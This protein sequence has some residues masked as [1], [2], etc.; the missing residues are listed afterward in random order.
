LS[1]AADLLQ[2]IICSIKIRQAPTRHDSIDFKPILTRIFRILPSS[3]VTAHRGYDSENNHVLDRKELHVLCVISA[4][5]E[6][7]PIWKTHARYRKQM[8]LG[9]C[10]M[11]CNEKNKK[12]ESIISVIKRL[13]G[14]RYFGVR[15]VKTSENIK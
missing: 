11:H 15:Y 8:K 7:G 14:T 4:R 6:R 1:I 12:H 2:Q 13:F 5:Y 9:Y 10:R 3:G